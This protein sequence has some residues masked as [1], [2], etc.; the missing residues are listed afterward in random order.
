[1]E[2]I[3]TCKKIYIYMFVYL[4]VFPSGELKD[5]VWVEYWMFITNAFYQMVNKH[6]LPVEII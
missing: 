3:D 1:M 6:G 2:R 4:P 5:D